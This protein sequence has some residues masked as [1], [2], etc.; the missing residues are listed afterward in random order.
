MENL[1]KIHRYKALICGRVQGIFFRDSV[2][3]RADEL[4]LVGWV[5]NKDHD[6][7]EVL[8]EGPKIYLDKLIS[9]CRNEVDKASID[10]IDVDKQDATGEFSD[11]VVRY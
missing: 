11:F 6:K 3:K 2:K 4:N 10:S 9:F 8:V 1:E 5:R 7:V